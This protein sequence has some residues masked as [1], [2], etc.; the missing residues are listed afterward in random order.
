M[1][2][3]LASAIARQE[4]YG[5]PGPA[6][7][8]NN[9]GNLMSPPGGQWAGQTGVDANGFAVFDN[10]QDG[11]NALDKDISANAGLSLSDFISK[12]APPSENN[13]AAYISNVS[14]WTGASPDESVADILAGNYSSGGSSALPSGTVAVPD[15]TF[16]GIDLTTLSGSVSGWW[17]G[18]ADSMNVDPT[19]LGI[20]AGIL[21]L[22]LAWLALKD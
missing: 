10:P 19:T 14:S 17:S 15:T 9:P 22:G 5:Q 3:T 4:G 21:A 16:A 8:N 11:W 13:T 20:G 12:Y 18:L 2:S 6:T 1:P 7:R